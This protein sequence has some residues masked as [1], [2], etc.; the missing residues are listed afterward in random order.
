MWD[1]PEYSGTEE[2]NEERILRPDGKIIFKRAQKVVL[3]EMSV[4]WIENRE[5]KL[6]EKIEKY[7]DV[8]RNLKIDYPGFVVEQATFIIDVLGGFSSHLKSNIAKIGYD[9]VTIE[10]IVTKLQKIVLS[11]ASYITN[12]FKM[13]FNI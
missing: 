6:I 5:S 12:K 9:C 3:L 7:K 2:E 4:P 1:I 11:E 10:K 13:T 8:L